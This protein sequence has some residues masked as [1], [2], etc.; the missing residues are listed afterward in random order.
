[1]NRYREK[2]PRFPFAAA[3]LLA[4]AAVFGAGIW[5]SANT[6]RAIRPPVATQPSIKQG[7]VAPYNRQNRITD[8]DR[9]VLKS[10]IENALERKN[11]Q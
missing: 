11:E 6:A 3:I 4:G 5:H 8:I 7:P 1:M 10:I 9:E 2:E